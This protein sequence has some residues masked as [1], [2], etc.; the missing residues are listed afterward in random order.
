MPFCL[1]GGF[2]LRLVP[3]HSLFKCGRHYFAGR[4]DLRIADVHEATSFCTSKEDMH[5]LDCPAGAFLFLGARYGSCHIFVPN[6]TDSDLFLE[7]VAGC[8]GGLFVVRVARDGLNCCLPVGI[9]RQWTVTCFDMKK[10]LCLAVEE[11]NGA[12]V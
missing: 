3:G 5:G 12:K 1:W 4:N 11:K 6:V 10:K 9:V 7:N 8:L 2:C